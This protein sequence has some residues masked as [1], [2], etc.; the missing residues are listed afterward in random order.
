MCWNTTGTP[1]PDDNSTSDGVGTG[2]FTSRITDLDPNTAYYVRA[3][4]IS[5][6]GMGYGQELTFTTSAATQD[7][8]GSSPGDA[9]DATTAPDLRVAVTAPT[10]VANVGD[11]LAFEVDVQNVGDGDATGVV[12]WFPLPPGTEFVSAWLIGG[13]SAQSAPLNAY[14]E[15]DEIAVELANVLAAEDVQIELI[16]RATA[17]GTLTLEAS[18]SSAEQ[19]TPATAQANADVE[20]DEV[21]LEIVNTVTPIGAC[22]MFGFTTPMLLTLGLLAMKRRHC[23]L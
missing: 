17:S 15:G 16:L 6:V 13:Q 3:F 19:A 20:V 18:V 22:G 1:T 7:D 12:L 8:D 4:A 14:V 21:Y 2:R 9:A 11:E 10:T 5:S 23:R